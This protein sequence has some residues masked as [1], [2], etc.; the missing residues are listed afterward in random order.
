MNRRKFI[1]RTAAQV[2][3]F[4]LFGIPVAKASLSNSKTTNIE[5]ST[6]KG[7]IIYRTLGRTGIKVP[8][9]NMGVMNANLPGLVTQ[10]YNNGVRLFDTAWFYQN[11]MNEKMLGETLET[12]GVRDESTIVTK[13]YLKETERDLYKPE[14]KQLFID[15]FEESL[16]RLKTNYVDVLLY[17]ASSD[18]KEHNNPHILEAFDEL[19]KEGKYKFKGVSLHGDDAALLDEIAE[20]GYYDVVMVMINIAFKDNEKLIKSIENAASKGVGIIAMKTQCGGGGNMWWKS[21]E[22]KREAIGDLNHKAMLKWVMQH[23]FIATAIP[24][25]TSYEQME[26]NLSVNYSLEYTAEE[27][28][29]MKKADVLASRAFCT[30][31]KKCVPGCPKNVDI[32]RLMRTHMYAYQYRN[33][34]HAVA[35]E[36][37]IPNN[38]GLQNCYLCEECSAA[39]SRSINIAGNIN[40]LKEL[41]FRSANA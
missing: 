2:A 19:K 30:D 10:S 24:G 35:T 6:E 20:T 38:Q 41:N 1:S 22:D 25:Y 31:C 12:M 36:K 23:E 26:E 37:C 34:E 39:C 32:P 3:L 9:V 40:R 21:R 5:Q 8:L 16:S 11:G 27:Q 14:T 29:F 4:N 15:R 18:N 28:E 13:I 7:E 17:H 33:M